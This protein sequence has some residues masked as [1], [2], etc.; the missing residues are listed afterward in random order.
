M[1]KIKAILFKA[2]LFAFLVGAVIVFINFYSY[3]FA[4]TVRGE[5]VGIRY[6]SDNMAIVSSTN[7]KSEPS[8]KVFSFSIGI[9][10]LKTGEIIT[11]SSEDRQLGVVKEGQCAT[12]KF[13]PYPPWK[14]DKDGTYFNARLEKLYENCNGQSE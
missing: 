11:S 10:D 1:T 14:L 7:A 12:V 4:K 2:L 8:S 3:I 5:V 13:F 9:K 6:L